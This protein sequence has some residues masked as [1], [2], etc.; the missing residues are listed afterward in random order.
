MTDKD[1]KA[2]EVGNAIESAKLAIL[3]AIENSVDTVNGVA[4]MTLRMYAETIAILEREQSQQRGANLFEVLNKIGS[5]SNAS[6]L[7]GDDEDD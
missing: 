7:I 6:T 2:L 1:R 3:K 5:I 4:P